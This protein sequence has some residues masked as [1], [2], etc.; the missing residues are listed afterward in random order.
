MWSVGCRSILLEVSN[1]EFLI[2]QLIYK[3]VEDFHICSCFDG[4]FEE[5]GTN[6]APATASFRR[7]FGHRAR[8]IWR[9]L[10]ISY[11]D[12]WKEEFTKTHHE[13]QTP[14]KQTSPKKFRQWQLTYWQGLSKIYR[15]GFNHVWMQMVATSSTCYDVVIFLTQWGKSASN[16]VVIS[17]LVVKLLKNCRVW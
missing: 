14:W 6:Y 17:L 4:F 13:P 2:V 12:I 8:L 11:G 15:A 16:F 9:H 3:G 1:W 10:I 7:D 5:D